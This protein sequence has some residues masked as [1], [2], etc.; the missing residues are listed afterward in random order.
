MRIIGFSKKWDKLQKPEHTT[1]RFP[2]KDADKGRD[3][4]F[5]ETV[6][7]VYKPRSKTQREF[8]QIAEIIKKEPK[9]IEDITEEEAVEDGFESLLMMWMFLGQP[10]M[11]KL[12]NKLTLRVKNAGQLS[13]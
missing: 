9:A 5:G 11:K 13:S 3:W 4:K 8:I 7:E 10:R 2:R 6:Q 12:I 1:F